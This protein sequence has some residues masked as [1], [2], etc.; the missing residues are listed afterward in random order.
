MQRAALV[1]AFGIPQC[2]HAKTSPL[3]AFARP[4]PSL[5]VPLPLFSLLKI[6]RSAH[7]SRRGV[8][9]RA[10][11][12]RRGHQKPRRRRLATRSHDARQMRIDGSGHLVNLVGSE[13]GDEVLDRPSAGDEL[14]CHEPE[15]LEVLLLR[16]HENRRVVVLAAEVLALDDTGLHEGGDGH[17]GTTGNDTQRPK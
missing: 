2:A 14:R 7:H 9:D 17:D 13:A 8:P 6:R 10:T 5:S 3:F 16:F 12:A 4:P 1:F 11:L 15:E